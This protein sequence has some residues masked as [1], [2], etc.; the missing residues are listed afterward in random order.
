MARLTSE[1]VG[2]FYQH[3]PRVAVVVTAGADGK[4]NAMTAAWHMP[5]SKAPPRYGVAI[6]TKRFT[7]Q[8]VTRSKE[9]GINFLPFE[10][11]EVA[12]AVGGSKG[13]G[14]D[15]FQ[16][17]NLATFRAQKIAVP[18]LTAAYTAY[19]CRLIDDRDYGDHRF[20]VGEIVA[21]HRL[22]EAFTAEE[23]LDLNKVNPLLYLG[24]ELYLTTTK[25]TR[26]LS[27]EEY[28]K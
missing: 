20:L 17:F 11:A 1:S 15:K 4:N 9:F 22:S 27:H 6:S 7:Y 24:H 2:A 23:T 3:Y 25:N 10:A 5:L 28:G 12:A 8:L 13:E 18:L 16:V 26:H 14:I 21:V 19:E